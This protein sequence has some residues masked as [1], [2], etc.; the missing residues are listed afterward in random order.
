MSELSDL[1][2]PV[3]TER[4]DPWDRDVSFR[5]IS[6]QQLIE[7]NNDWAAVH[8][9]DAKA[10]QLI[11]FYSELLA[12]CCID[13]IATSGDWQQSAT[14]QTI[15]DLGTIAARVSGLLV[16]EEKKSE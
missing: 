9:S 13:P 8:G 7:L 10:E 1:D 14:M 15:I 4:Y 12:Y 5:K 16:E 11:D 3:H 2:R 6:A